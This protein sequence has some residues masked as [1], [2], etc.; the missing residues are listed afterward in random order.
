MSRL[1]QQFDEDRAL[2]NAAFSVLKSDIEHAKEAFSGKAIAGRVSSRVGDGAKD[3]AQIA[4][5]HADDNRGILAALIG[6]LLLWLA[7]EPILDVLGLGS[8]SDNPDEDSAPEE[9][10]ELSA[11]EPAPDE[12]ISELVNDNE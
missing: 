3:V 6:A 8:A 5:G 12:N 11:N 4:K 10:E 1:D 9:H 7:R 2:R